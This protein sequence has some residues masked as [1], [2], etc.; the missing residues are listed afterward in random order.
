MT[1]DNDHIELETFDEKDVVGAAATDE[2]QTIEAKYNISMDVD[3]VLG[4]KKI[5][6]STLL[7][8]SRG[9]VIEL[10]TV[11]GEPV[12][13]VANGKVIAKGDLVKVNGNHVGVTLKEIVREHISENT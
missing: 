6:V 8:L 2:N 1:E 13:V 10:E 3:I 4:T 11:I 9:A 5:P 7:G 12:N